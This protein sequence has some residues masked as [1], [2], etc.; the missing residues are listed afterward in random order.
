MPQVPY[1]GL[2]FTEGHVQILTDHLAKQVYQAMLKEDSPLYQS[3]MLC[4]LESAGGLLTVQAVRTSESA[5]P[6]G[7]GGPSGPS[8]LP[9]AAT[10]RPKR[11]AAPKRTARARNDDAAG[12]GQDAELETALAGLDGEG[13]GDGAGDDEEAPQDGW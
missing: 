13:A 10:K 6:D 1:L 7:P 3:S 5:T 8:A 2:A 12:Q 4:Q 9:Q 11:A